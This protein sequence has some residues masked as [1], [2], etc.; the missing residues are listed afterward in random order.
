MFD[1]PLPDAI[2]GFEL[3]GDEEAELMQRLWPVGEIDVEG[4]SVPVTDEILR[5]FLKTKTRP[6]MF[7][8]PPIE[9][10]AEVVDDP[11]TQSRVGVYTEGRN[12]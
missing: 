9:P 7:H 4:S 5:R 2:E 10:G 3:S 12:R 11:L 1:H 8:Q 6:T